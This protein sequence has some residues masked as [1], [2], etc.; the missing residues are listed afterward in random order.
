MKLLP[1][2]LT[3]SLILFLPRGAQ[4]E[5][6]VTIASGTYD[7]ST[8]V[9][10][11]GTPANWIR[12]K[13][14][15]PG[16]VTLRGGGTVDK[17]YV[18]LDGFLFDAKLDPRM[19]RTPPKGAG[20]AIT[21]N[22]VRIENS[23]VAGTNSIHTGYDTN[24]AV[25]CSEFDGGNLGGGVVVQSGGD[26]TL[27][28]VT[29]YGFKDAFSTWETVGDTVIKNS[30]IRNNHNGISLEGKSLTMQ[31]S[32]VW[33]NPNHQFSIKSLLPG[34]FF[35]LENNLLVD[36]QDMIK[37]GAAWPGVDDLI[38]IH[39]TFWIAP[40]NPCAVYREIQASNV[41]DQILIQDNI[42]V[43]V[44]DNW[45]T[46]ASSQIPITT[47][48][49][50]LLYRHAG[51]AGDEF[52]IDTVK[53]FYEDWVAQTG[54]DTNS[55]VRQEPLF[56]DAPLNND[57]TENRWGFR[58]PDTVAEARS[59][60][61]LI[62]GS[63]GRNAASDGLDMGIIPGSVA[64]PVCGDGVCS[65]G[66]TCSSC[67]SD[68]GVC[69]VCTDNDGDGYGN[70]GSSACSAG[71]QLDCNDGNAGINP[72]ATE[73]CGNGIDEN[74][75]GSDLACGPTCGDGTCD[76]GES[77]ST[78]SLDCGACPTGCTDGT[79]PPYAC[80]GFI[81]GITWAS[82]ATQDAQDSDNLPITWSD[83]NLLYTSYGDGGGFDERDPF[84]MGWS[85]VSGFPPNHVGQD[86]ASTD[87]VPRGS[88][89]SGEKGSGMVSVDGILY[90]GV[91]NADNAGN[92][93]EFWKSTDKAINWQKSTWKFQELGFCALLNFGQDYTGGRSPGADP[94][95]VYMYSPN[96]QSA[97]SAY[98]DIVLA[99]V[100]KHEVLNRNAW[101]FFSGTPSSPTWSS[102]IAARASI[103]HFTLNVNR[104]DVTYNEPL[105]R[106]LLTMRN[107]EDDGNNF[108]IY[109]APEPWGPWTTVYYTE[110]WLDGT[111]LS[112][113]ARNQGWGDS[114]HIP[115]KWISADGKEF[116]LVYSGDDSFRI[117]R[118]TLTVA[119][120]PPVCGNDVKESGEDCDGTDLGD[121]TC[122]GLGFSGGQLACTTD[123]R[124]DTGGCTS[125]SPPPPPKNL[126]RTDVLEPDT[127]PVLTTIVVTPDLA[128]VSIND[129]LQF[130]AA[131][132][133][134]A[135]NPMSIDPVWTVTAGTI[136]A[137][138]LFTA[139]ASPAQ[140][141]ITAT[142]PVTGQAS[143]LVIDPDEFWPTAGW[144]TATPAEMGM[145][146]TL[147]E[148][149][150]DYALTGGGSGYI[151][152]GGR[153]VLSWG[154]PAQPHGILSATKSIGVTVLGL[155][156][157]DGLL[158]LGDAAQ[159]YLPEL[160]VPPESNTATGWLDDIT[161]LQLATQTAGFAKAGVY[162]DLLF[163]PGT[164][165][166]YSDGGANWLADVLT[167]LYGQDLKTL[168]FARVFDFLGIQTTELV[169]RDHAY[170]EITINGIPRREFGSGISASVD[171]MARIGYL[172]LRGGLWE[173][174]Q[175]IPRSFVDQARTTVDG[176]AGLP[177]DNDTQSRFAGASDHYGLLWWNNHDGSLADVP[178]DAYWAFGKDENLI[179][180]IPSLDIVV[181]RGGSAWPGPVS[182]SYYVRLEPFL[183]PIAQS[184]VG[185]VAQSVVG[186]Q[187]PSQMVFS[188]AIEGT[189][190][191]ALR[192]TDDLGA[193]GTDTAPVKK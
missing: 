92:M 166:A 69:P 161:F 59:W 17:S 23:T 32:V 142:G 180:V 72:G 68:C 85:S 189:F 55:I 148:Q 159:T 9:A 88:G 25:S 63:P 155:A 90:L 132:T 37:A 193:S 172:Y 187:A 93:C 64:P 12:Y 136:D 167:V 145:D 133:D 150:R 147:L 130:S 87:S 67:S 141:T 86:I 3:A 95:Y 89:R 81:T 58:I 40:N 39:N 125:A 165:W 84:S 117:R 19:S 28:N 122:Q 124:F 22:F 53:L 18:I 45:L 70:P 5:T 186:N 33:V 91:R 168:M 43:S 51:N 41:R 57:F 54:E 129:S 104:L 174:Q 160:G 143:A 8:V 80:S 26:I 103:F 36:A 83:D 128:T 176:V 56:V 162:I 135:G 11:S 73:I 99:R 94:N 184:V 71:P 108:G 115:S 82:S 31:D 137:A 10:Q 182:P 15:T 181:S 138:G 156:L 21:A 149:A 46:I 52:N 119:G 188:S 146:Q 163:E 100:P 175:I 164:T 44:S 140:V 121:E 126:R 96:G 27:D 110:E 170:R 173:S 61:Q 97:Y 171:A 144:A 24:D 153:L 112:S 105:G 151:T 178:T 2:L 185:P 78:C 127:A 107:R 183:V 157:Q 35:R 65:G 109:D 131:G 6:L 60:F 14:A 77:C 139:P 192:V 120:S 116:Y 49:Y 29:I 76:A 106:Y 118:A 13:P 30:L 50:N 101:E 102:D 74:C 42:I 62:A 154:A 190:T 123:C 34:S 16:T 179:V 191:V 169:W 114:Q 79:T 158:N 152:R 20:V 75:S 1:S 111:P 177:V 48:N 47:S 134:Q 38:V 4:A 7:V 113:M 98:D 66:E